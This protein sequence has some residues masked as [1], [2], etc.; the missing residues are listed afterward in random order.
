MNPS[1]WNESC[2]L[3]RAVVRGAYCDCDEMTRPNPLYILCPAPRTLYV[4]GASAGEQDSFI[5]PPIQ[6]GVDRIVIYIGRS[7][8]HAMVPSLHPLSPSSLL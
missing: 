6:E 7:S 4:Y 8:F 1:I 3:I 2:V 5:R